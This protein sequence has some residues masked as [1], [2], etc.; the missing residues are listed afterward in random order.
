MYVCIYIYIYKDLRIYNTYNI[1]KYNV[2]YI[3]LNIHY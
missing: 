2:P 3:L 1:Y